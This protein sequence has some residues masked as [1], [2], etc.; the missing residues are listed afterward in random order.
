MSGWD[1]S[2]PQ[3]FLALRFVPNF[4]CPRDD[5][6]SE[7]I[8]GSGWL[9]QP[10]RK[11]VFLYQLIKSADTKNKNSFLVAAGYVRVFFVSVD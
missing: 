8:F 2:M 3:I 11:I 10:I 7:I 5:A 4:W 1:R 6:C 9:R